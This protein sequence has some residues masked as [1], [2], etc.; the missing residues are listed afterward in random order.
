MKL[1][2]F[3]AYG[4]AVT[5]CYS[6]PKASDTKADAAPD[7]DALSFFQ[8]RASNIEPDVTEPDVTEQLYEQ[9][10]QA[11]KAANAPRL[12][13]NRW[14]YFM[15]CGLP[16][17]TQAGSKDGISLLKPRPLTKEGRPPPPESEEEL[18]AKKQEKQW[19][20][21]QQRVKEQTG[22]E[23]VGFVI[24][25]ITKAADAGFFSKPSIFTAQ[26]HYVEP[27]QN[28]KYVGDKLWLAKWAEETLRAG[29]IPGDLKLIYG[30]MTD[31]YT[32][33]HVVWDA[34]RWVRDHEKLLNNP[35]EDQ[36]TFYKYMTQMV[37]KNHRPTILDSLRVR[38]K[39]HAGV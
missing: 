11:Q 29:Q 26:L 22:C 2:A 27:H 16:E 38:P 3:F 34:S 19:K 9:A 35:K 8:G 7:S 13:A 21:A 10:V 25:Q 37:E 18:T 24:G 15:S 17:N 23:H 31:E 36:Y 39:P 32:Y 30:G 12:K 4:A 14:Y 5:L 33:K 20:S 6:H 28:P 1:L